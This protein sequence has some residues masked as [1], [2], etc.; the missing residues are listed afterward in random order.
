MVTNIEDD[1]LD[2]YGTVENIK[3]AF[4]E[5][6]SH[7]TDP[8]GAAVVCIDSQGVRDVLPRINQKVITYGLSED[9]AYRAVNKRYENGRVVLM[10]AEADGYSEA[11]RFRSPA[12]IM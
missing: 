2:H 10:Y 1:H 12:P 11:F 8:N 3:T 5:F 6:I 7:I 4:V 9:A